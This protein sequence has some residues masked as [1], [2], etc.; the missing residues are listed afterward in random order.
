MK[1]V[2]PEVEGRLERT[3]ISELVKGANALRQLVRVKIADDEDLHT[4]KRALLVCVEFIIGLREEATQGNGSTPFSLLRAQSREERG[5]GK[6]LRKGGTSLH[7]Y[8]KQ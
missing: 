3:E 8:S 2:P 6:G 4:A 5:A 1:K 7:P